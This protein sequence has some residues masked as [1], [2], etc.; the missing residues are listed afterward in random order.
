MVVVALRIGLLQPALR[1]QL[2]EP[3]EELGV[4]FVGSN[5]ER[6][7]V[8]FEDLALGLHIL[9][10]M[11]IVM[12]EMFV[13]DIGMP[14]ERWNDIKLA[15]IKVMDAVLHPYLCVTVSDIV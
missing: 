7:F 12:L 15:R 5:L 11:Y 13:T 9:I 1:V 6:E 10:D 14:G 8:L 3:L 4:A 2:A